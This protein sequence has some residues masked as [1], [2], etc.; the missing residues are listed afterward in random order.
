[1]LPGF[2]LESAIVTKKLAVGNHNTNAIGPTFIFLFK[3]NKGYP[4][5]TFFAS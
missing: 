1:V 2:E 3:L 4:T 5:E